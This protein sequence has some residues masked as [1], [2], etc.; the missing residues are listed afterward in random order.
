MLTHSC[1]LLFFYETTAHSLILLQEMKIGTKALELL[2]IFCDVTFLLNGTAFFVKPN[3]I[4]CIKKISTLLF[5]PISCNNTKNDYRSGAIHPVAAA[6][7][8]VGKIMAL[9]STNSFIEMKD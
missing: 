1:T 3:K 8:K 9:A 5:F 6:L 4:Y 7:F 2:I